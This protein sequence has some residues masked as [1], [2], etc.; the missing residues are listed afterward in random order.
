M[1][2]YVWELE[3]SVQPLWEFST[4]T[5][6]IYAHQCMSKLETSSC[7]PAPVRPGQKCIYTFYFCLS[8]WWSSSFLSEVSSCRPQPSQEKIWSCL[9]VIVPAGFLKLLILCPDNQIKCWTIWREPLL[10][11]VL[12]NW[13]L[14]L[15]GSIYL[16]SYSGNNKQLVLWSTRH[17]PAHLREA[18]SRS[19]G[20]INSVIQIKWL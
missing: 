12:I 9:Y 2:F 16:I 4:W 18:E 1:C 6:S 10:Q 20:W 8:S 11:A 17:L 5:A 19:W 3:K 7:I 13:K 14:F 15:S